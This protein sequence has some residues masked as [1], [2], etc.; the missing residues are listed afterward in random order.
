[1]T[2]ATQLFTNNAVSLLAAPIGS[3]S[4]SLTVMAGYGSLY[5]QPVGDGSDYFLITLEDQAATTREI[6]RVTARVGDTFTQILRA[7]EGTIAQAWSASLG[8]DT[9]VDH[10]VTAETM[11]LA[12]LL[13]QS[14]AGTIA[15]QSNNAQVGVPAD[16]LNFSGAGVTVIDGGTTKNIYIPG[17]GASNGLNPSASVVVPPVTTQTTAQIA[18]SDTNRLMKFWV[19]MYNTASG[20]A[21]AFEVLAVVQGVLSTNTETVVWNETHRIGH[22]FNGTIQITLDVLNKLMNLKWV[23]SDPSIEVIV[24][25]THI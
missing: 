18:Y 15:V 21:Q 6:I 8:S 10:R 17:G 20:N 22:L 3:S 24:T 2:Y 19:Q 9:L 13:P 23:N 14:A 12:M 11:R 7:Q 16:T 5:P 1:M 4:T 25:V